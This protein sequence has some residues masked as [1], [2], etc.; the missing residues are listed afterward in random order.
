MKVMN[1]CQERE[2]IISPS[3]SN[4]TD[5]SGQLDLPSWCWRWL[6]SQLKRP[7]FFSKT[8]KTS[9]VAQ[10]NSCTLDW[11]HQWLETMSY[12]FFSAVCS[13]TGLSVLTANIVPVDLYWGDATPPNPTQP[14]WSDWNFLLLAHAAPEVVLKI[15]VM[16]QVG[17]D[18]KNKSTTASDEMS[19]LRSEQG[20]VACVYVRVC[21]CRGEGV[22][23]RQR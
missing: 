5:Q 23:K 21:L 12:D 3:S 10:L 8:T 2:D 15:G 1:Q 4:W 19:R 16:T 20:W 18:Y 11:I 13:V 14:Q 17:E 6:A 22:L 7:F 9:P